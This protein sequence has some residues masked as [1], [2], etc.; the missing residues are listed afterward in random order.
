ME[1][2]RLEILKQKYYIYNLDTTVD[3][4][5]VTLAKTTSKLVAIKIALQ[6]KNTRLERYEVNIF[7]YISVLV[8]GN[9]NAAIR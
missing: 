1:G 3:K 7:K 8:F 9:N 5:N 4:E 6:M 2:R